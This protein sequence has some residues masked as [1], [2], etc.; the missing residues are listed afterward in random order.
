MSISNVFQPIDRAIQMIR[1]VHI[2][3]ANHDDSETIR[4]NFHTIE[5]AQCP[6][7]VALSY[8]W[9]PPDDGTSILVDNKPLIIRENLYFALREIRK[10]MYPP[11]PCVR[12]MTRSK[13]QPLTPESNHKE[14]LESNAWNHFWID[15][16][17]INQDDTFERNHQVNLMGS[18]YSQA[19][20]VLS[21][22]GPE[23]QHTTLA[24]TFFDKL[25]KIRSRKARLSFYEA[26]VLPERHLRKGLEDLCKSLYWTRLWVVQEL[27]L[28]RCIILLCGEYVIS[29]ST[30]SILRVVP[31]HLTYRQFYNAITALD[32][33]HQWKGQPERLEDLV[34]HWDLDKL[35]CTDPRDR[36]YGLFALLDKSE[37]GTIGLLEVDYRKTAEEVYSVIFS[38][39]QKRDLGPRYTR[40]ILKRLLRILELNV[41][42]GAFTRQEEI[43]DLIR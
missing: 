40:N 6:P 22:L 30:F 13:S 21:W 41:G 1:L 25:S 12:H 17:C 24:I 39:M 19:A 43:Y 37:E 8:T 3:P 2:L 27:V 4:C 29:W 10:K 18:I 32:R 5:L 7:Y 26:E 11:Q 14:I 9:G 42:T 16:I 15:A 34:L 20:L 33:R 35:Q 38:Y 31:G 28:A 23:G 36:V